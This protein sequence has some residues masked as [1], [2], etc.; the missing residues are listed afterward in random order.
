MANEYPKGKHPNSLKN[1]NMIK[2][3]EVKNPLG[4]NKGIK[5]LSDVLKEALEGEKDGKNIKDLIVDV[6]LREAVRGNDKM[7]N[8]LFNRTEGMPKQT[9]DT[10][11]TS[12]LGVIILP[13]KETAEEENEEIDKN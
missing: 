7:L 6:I 8:L 9:V 2:P 3:G 10:N 5:N 11:I 1:L 12:D 4:K 13:N